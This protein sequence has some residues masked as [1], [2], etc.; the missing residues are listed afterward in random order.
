MSSLLKI[1][2]LNVSYPGKTV[3]NDLSLSLDKGELC[4]LLGLNGSGKTSLIRAA[5]GLL[6]TDG[7]INVSGQNVMELDERNRAKLISYL[8]QASGIEEGISVIHAV[9]M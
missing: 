2:G 8:P 7:K 1:D 9:L 6:R 5:C 3:L 4:A